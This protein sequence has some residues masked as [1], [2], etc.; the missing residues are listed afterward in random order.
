VELAAQVEFL[1]EVYWKAVQVGEP[2]I[3]PPRELERVRAQ[4]LAKRSPVQVT[5]TLPA[6]PDA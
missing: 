2:A 3:L 5:D 4:M 1:A 6:A